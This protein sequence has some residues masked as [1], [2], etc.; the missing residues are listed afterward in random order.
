LI[1]DEAKN[2][3]RD[4]QTWKKKETRVI[5]ILFFLL[6]LRFG[7][8]TMRY[9]PIFTYLSFH[10]CAS[11]NELI[12]IYFINHSN[13]RFSKVKFS[14]YFKEIFYFF[15][16]SFWTLCKNNTKRSLGTW[17]SF[18]IN[19]FQWDLGYSAKEFKKTFSNEIAR[20]KRTPSRNLSNSGIYINMCVFICDA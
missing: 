8:H 12:F 11:N 16:I 7:R 9:Y 13:I 4:E 2:V 15:F 14:F 1:V 6:F 5:N 19:F 17:H 10:L 18:L 20:R 3:E